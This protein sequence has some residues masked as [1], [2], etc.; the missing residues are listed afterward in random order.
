MSSQHRL[1]ACQKQRTSAIHH[2][3]NGYNSA[4][5]IQF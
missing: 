4:V 5:S 1:D 3:L 2:M